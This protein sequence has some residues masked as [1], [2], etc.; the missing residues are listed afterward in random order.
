MTYDVDLVA[1]MMQQ[2]D[3]QLANGGRGIPSQE[4]LSLEKDGPIGAAIECR[5]YAENPILN[6]S[7]SPG[8]L[9]YV[10]M[11][12][13]ES[14]S[15]RSNLTLCSLNLSAHSSLVS[16]ASQGKGIRIDGWIATGTVV[17]PSY[18]P[19]LAKII[20]LSQDRNEA[21]KLMADV[22][23]TS[24]VQGS[25]TNLSFLA[26]IVKSQPYLEGK[27]LTS[28]LSNQ[29][30]FTFRP[31]AIEVLSGGLNTT[32]QDL[33]RPAIG[34]GVPIGGP[35]DLLSF[36]LANLLVGNEA[37]TE[38][39]EI[40]LSG[41]ELRFHCRSSIA[42]TGASC[43]VTLDGKE[44]DNYS[45][46]PVSAGSILKIGAIRGSGF[47][48]YLA[49][50]DGFPDIPRYL[51]SKATCTALSVSGYQGRKLLVG[52]TLT[53][54]PST[55]SSLF[56]LPASARLDQLFAK[57]DVWSLTCMRG[58][59]DDDEFISKAG[60]EQEEWTVSGE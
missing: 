59:F 25:P 44:I 41:P 49:I 8:L 11:K 6:F 9:Q 53:I 56:S 39:L 57:D 40:T 10:S 34:H 33:G 3:C 14:E 7:P 60:L 23:E 17:S 46:I 27:T 29:E 16:L 35:A 26:Q 50:K 24:K 55:H 15:C 5:L 58:P 45:R 28:F 48:A 1:L 19:M 32:V 43:S 12:Q 21:A 4:L 52:D 20:T 47:R 2:A 37:G 13:G 51:G 38:A 18:D 22:L 36:K 42:L 31:N 30:L 54:K